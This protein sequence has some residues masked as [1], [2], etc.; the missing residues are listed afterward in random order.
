MKHESTVKQEHGNIKK[1]G[2]EVMEIQEEAGRNASIFKKQA[3][4]IL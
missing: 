4:L 2:R 1:L 3:Q